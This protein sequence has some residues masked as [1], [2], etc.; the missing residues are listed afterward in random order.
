MK[1][2]KWRL[3]QVLQVRT[4]QEQQKR[5]E[6]LELTER[7]AQAHSK[8]IFQKRILKELA[9]RIAEKKLHQR[10]ND[11]EMFLRHS[12]VNNERIKI[13]KEKI[14]QLETEQKQ[15][16]AEVLE[17]RKSK[18]ALEKLRQEA[19]REFIHEQEKLEQ[20]Q[21]DE[22]T[23]LSFAQ[24]LTQSEALLAN[25]SLIKNKAD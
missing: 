16:I 10:L 20:K 14:S 17:L 18:E 22:R 11:Q 6:L 4:I 7:L 1:K 9:E 21:I 8:L 2:F 3:E 25:G 5:A 13:L 24:K 15:K 23:S 19:K 12:A